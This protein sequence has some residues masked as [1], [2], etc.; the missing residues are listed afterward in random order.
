[1][2]Q[3]RLTGLDLLKHHK[4]QHETRHLKVMFAGYIKDGFKP[5]YTEYYSALLP[6]MLWNKKYENTMNNGGSKIVQSLVTHLVAGAD[7]QKEN[8]RVCYLSNGDAA[9]YYYGQLICIVNFN[10]NYI[11]IQPNLMRTKSTKERLNRILMKFTGCQ[12]FQKEKKWYVYDP[13]RDQDSLVPEG[14]CFRVDFIGSCP[15]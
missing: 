5:S 6:L 2:S 11:T 7:Y 10:N 14:A 15:E 9:I 13:E 1:M 12:L 8:D 3:I 4:S